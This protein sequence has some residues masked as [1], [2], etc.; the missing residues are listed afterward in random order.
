M[1]DREAVTLEPSEMPSGMWPS[2]ERQQI[3]KDHGCSCRCIDPGDHLT[4][5]EWEQDPFCVQHPVPYIMRAT[6]LGLCQELERL[7]GD[8]MEEWG[9]NWQ[10]QPAARRVL[11]TEVYESLSTP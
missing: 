7:R 6:V 9:H 8:V 2:A 4:P 10:T 11:G 1:S 3:A 5:A